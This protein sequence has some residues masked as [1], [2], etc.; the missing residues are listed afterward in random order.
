M[1]PAVPGEGIDF[2]TEKL[3]PFTW[4]LVWTCALGLALLPVLS[5]LLLYTLP[6]SHNK[7]KRIAVLVLGDIGRS[8]RMQ[9]H[10]AS[11]AKAGWQVDLVG[12]KGVANFVYHF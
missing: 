9:N 5:L 12:F 7:S 3:S 11:L 6:F 4:T 10:T 1:N 2:L 8:P